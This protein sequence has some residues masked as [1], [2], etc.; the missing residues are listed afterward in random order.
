[1]ALRRRLSS[2]VLVAAALV[3]VQL[4]SA[5]VAQAAVRVLYY[6]ASQAQEF[7]RSSARA[8]RTGTAG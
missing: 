7:V 2:L 5:G 1:M 4:A 3:G 6:D 8:H